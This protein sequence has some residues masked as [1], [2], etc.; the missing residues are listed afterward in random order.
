[1][2]LDEGLPD[3]G[4]GGLPG[5]ASTRG[6]FRGLTG[7]TIHLLPARVRT[8]AALLIVVPLLLCSCGD[9]EPRDDL[10]Y[11]V[12]EVC[13]Q[14]RIDGVTAEQ[15]SGILLDASRHGP[16]MDGIEAECGEEIASV[17]AGQP[18]GSG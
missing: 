6:I 12:W 8:W 7:P 2:S 16:V 5:T 4:E 17:F 9:Q 18:A 13:R 3:G 11:L 14:I 15:V 1:M 10:E